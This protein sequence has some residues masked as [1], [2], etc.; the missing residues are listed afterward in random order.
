VFAE[1]SLKLDLSLTFVATALVGP[2]Y[3]IF[4]S[5]QNQLQLWLTKRRS[6]VLTT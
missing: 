5:I 4:K 3:D 2:C 1:S 6:N